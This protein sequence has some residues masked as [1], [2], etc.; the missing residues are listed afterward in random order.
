MRNDLKEGACKLEAGGGTASAPITS[1]VCRRTAKGGAES[2]TYEL[3]TAGLL[4]GFGGPISPSSVRD[5]LYWP[6]R[7]QGSV[8]RGSQFGFGASTKVPVVWS[9]RRS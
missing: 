5:S 3:K 1:I 2:A 9:C 8:I 7:A 6:P 4:D